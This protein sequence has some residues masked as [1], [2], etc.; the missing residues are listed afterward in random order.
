VL[1]EGGDNQFHNAIPRPPKSRDGRQGHCRRPLKIKTQSEISAIL[2]G[3]TVT[4]YDVLVRIAT[5]LGIPRG[6]LGL[7]YDPPTV[8]ADNGAAAADLVVVGGLERVASVPVTPVTVAPSRITV[9]DVAQVVTTTREIRQLDARSGGWSAHEQVR[10][11]LLRTQPL[12]AACADADVRVALQAAVADLHLLAAWIAFDADLVSVCRAHLRA[13]GAYTTGEV[14]AAAMTHYVR[15]RL[16]L[17]HGWIDAALTEL[18]DGLALLD[19]DQVGEGL[20][21][22]RAAM[23]G[24]K[25][26]GLA[27]HG[28]VEAVGVLRQAA[29]TLAATDQARSTRVRPWLDFVD[30]VHLAAVAGA[31]HVALSERIPDSSRVGRHR[32]LAV[33]R[34]REVI[35][36]RPA[37][38]VRAR[39]LDLCALAGMYQDAGDLGAF[40]DVAEPALDLAATID[41]ARVTAALTRLHHRMP[42]DAGRNVDL[43]DR[44][45]RHLSRRDLS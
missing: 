42:A 43:A 40:V 26:L 31:V 10:V 25:A 27:H 3:R 35:S 33:A 12:L 38:Q 39:V 45:A 13:A 17:L 41:S 36:R 7:G 37:E 2:A 9:D 16:C 24:M 15:A 20:G 4:Y 6:R 18:R 34:L 23:L 29:D 8:P 14:T 19:G 28:R 32:D 30:D 11:H 22:A 44:I 1:D 21:R 5:G